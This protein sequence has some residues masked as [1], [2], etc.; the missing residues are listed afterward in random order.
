MVRIPAEK[1]KQ[2]QEEAHR[3][4]ILEI[5]MTPGAIIKIHKQPRKE[6]LKQKKAKSKQKK[7]GKSKQKKTS[8]SRNKTKT[9]K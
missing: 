1:K 4:K 5:L 8:G 7:S 2:L 9:S 3:R 6:R